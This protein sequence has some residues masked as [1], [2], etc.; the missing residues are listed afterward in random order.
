LSFLLRGADLICLG[1]EEIITGD[2]LI[3]EERIVSLG[4]EVTH[5]G[6]NTEVIECKGLQVFP[7]FFDMHV[8]FR[9]PGQTHK[10][11]IKSGLQA[12]AAGG[13]TGVA[14][15][16]NTSP[17]I[18]QPELVESLLAKGKKLQGP[19]YYQIGAATFGLSGEEFTDIPGL[20]K[21]GTVAISDDGQPIPDTNMLK[22]LLQWT[23]ELGFVYIEHCEDKTYEPED[24]LSEINM[25]YRDIDCLAQTGGNLHLA[26]ISCQK[27]LELVAEGKKEGLNLTCEVTPHHLALDQETVKKMGANARMNPPLRRREDVLALQQGV[28]EGLIDA[29]ATDHAPHTPGEKDVPIKKAPRGV[30]GLETAVGVIWNEL[31]HG[32]ELSPILLGHLLA[33]NPRRILGLPPE[34]IREGNKANFTVIDPAQKWRVDPQEF[35]SKSLNS[36]FSGEYLQGK[37]VLVFKNG[38]KIMEKGRVIFPAGRS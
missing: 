38:K 35:Y 12:A 9:E 10:E 26:H 11:E 23:L 32:M 27:S 16:A 17:V 25:V 31:F 3:E 37:P 15:M 2:L 7:G 36:A 5:P 20:F 22:E 34:D 28:A 33:E 29:I 13:F 24:P 19:D 14:A 1:K 6:E 30:V 21:G 4:K 18:D 8:H